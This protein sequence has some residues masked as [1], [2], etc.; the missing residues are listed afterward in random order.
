MVRIIIGDNMSALAG[1]G[2]VAIWHDVAPEGRADYYE[3][4][5]REHMPERA[6]VPGFIRGR[7]YLAEKGSPEYFNLYEVETV[8]VLTSAA[9]LERLNNPT[10]LTRRTV[11]HVRNTARSLCRVAASLG[12]GSGG[13][14]MTWQLEAAPDGEAALVEWLRE[15]LPALLAQ[16]GVIAAH[17][18]I[19][20]RAGSN[21]MT[22]E[23]KMRGTAT[24]V[25]GVIVLVEG[26]S[27]AALEAA[28]EREL[29]AA[30]LRAHGAIDPIQ[31]A[32]YRLETDVAKSQAAHRHADAALPAVSQDVPHPQADR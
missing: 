13:T 2:F 14:L 18:G 27:A 11:V 32:I 25:P 15:R 20:D 24:Q 30:G 28:G 17:I 12:S 16:P 6:N 19:A 23:R 8:G 29:A 10:P 26:I 7:R 22:E 5:N 1:E 3:W 9:Y 21:L 31:S 4:H